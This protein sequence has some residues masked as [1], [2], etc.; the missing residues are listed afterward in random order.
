MSEARAVLF[1]LLAG[2]LMFLAGFATG[3]GSSRNTPQMK[4]EPPAPKITHADGSQTLERVNTPPP[5]PLPVPP[6]AEAR[7]RVEVLELKPMTERSEIQ[8]DFVRL[9]DGTER[10]TAKGPA[11]AGGQDFTF[12]VPAQP[13][14]KWTLGGG[15]GFK[16]Y[17]AVGLR[18]W[19][20]IDIGAVIQRDRRDGRD[21]DAQ[22]VLLFRF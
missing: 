11:L 18:S 13:V 20:P 14:Q 9:K 15:V 22:A 2:G 12:E 17:T 4:A 10:A 1:G 8:I 3:R 7:T 21:W 6:M 5:P 16:R 19:G